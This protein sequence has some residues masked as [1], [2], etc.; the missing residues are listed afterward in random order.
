[1]ALKQLYQDIYQKFLE[2][3][4]TQKGYDFQHA[5]SGSTTPPTPTFTEKLK[6][7]TLNRPSRLQKIR[8][9]R[10]Q[11]QQEII[12]LKSTPPPK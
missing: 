12:H 2:R 6:A 9:V 8:A 5:P 4:D 11:R 10:D 1:M 3:K 7:W